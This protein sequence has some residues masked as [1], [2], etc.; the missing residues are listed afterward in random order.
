MRDLDVT[1]LSWGELACLLVSRAVAAGALRPG[2]RPAA[3]ESTSRDRPATGRCQGL[4]VWVSTPRVP[5]L[6]HVGARCGASPGGLSLAHTEG[7]VSLNSGRLL[8][9]AWA[10][11]SLHSS[12]LSVVTASTRDPGPSCSGFIRR[13]AGPVGSEVIRAPSLESMSRPSRGTGQSGR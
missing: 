6:S 3:V 9:W 1:F 5:F 11:N 7:K 2:G 12:S 10:Q 4:T 8:G 13:L